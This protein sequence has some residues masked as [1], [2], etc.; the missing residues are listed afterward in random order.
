LAGERIAARK[1]AS[2]W[3]AQSESSEKDQDSG[4]RESGLGKE[5]VWSTLIPAY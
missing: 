3:L 2:I 1:D 5:D 4:I